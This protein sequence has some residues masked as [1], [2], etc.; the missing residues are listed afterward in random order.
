MGGA[1]RSFGLVPE[2]SRFHARP[3]HSKRGLL[4]PQ[5]PAYGTEF[6]VYPGVWSPSGHSWSYDTSDSNKKK[7]I[8]WWYSATGPY[9][10][11][12]ATG[13][14]IARES[15]SYDVIYEAV[16]LDCDSPGVC[17]TGTGTGT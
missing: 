13:L 16:S 15:V 10:G 7:A 6:E 9:P 3:S 2:R 14:F 11:A 5:H 17:G 1:V 4:R 8:D 12:G